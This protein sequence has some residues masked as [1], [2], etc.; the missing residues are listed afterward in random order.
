MEAVN[1]TL[2]ETE[3]LFN[4]DDTG[5]GEVA[6]MPN[7]EFDLGRLPMPI[8]I[9]AGTATGQVTVCYVTE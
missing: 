7:V 3:L 5:G 8:L 6:R 2:R 1:G 9:P 4:G